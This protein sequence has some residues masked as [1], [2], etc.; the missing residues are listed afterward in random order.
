MNNLGLMVAFLLAALFNL[1]AAEW[2]WSVPAPTIPDRRAFLWVPPDCKQV[3]GLVVACHNMIEKSLFERSAFRAACAENDL[4]IVMIFSGHD[5]A[6][7]DDKNPDHPKRSALDIFLNPNFPKGEEDP[8]GAGEDL[9]KVLDA[10]AGE[11]G[12]EE[13]RHAPLMPVGHSSAGSFVWHLYK[14]D[15]SRIFAMMPFKTGSKED[16]PPGIPVFDVNSEWFEYGNSPMH[17]V[18]LTSPEGGARVAKFRA[19]HK[20]ALY[21]YYVDIGAGHCDASDDAI[22]IMRLFLKKVVAARIPEHAPKDASVPLKLVTVESGWLL[23]AATFGKPEGKPVAYADWK[24]DAKQSFWYLDKELAA[25]VQNHLVQQLAKKPQQI[26]FIQDGQ[27]SPDA[28]MY[29]FSPKFLDD[30]GTF[31]LQADFVDH[32]DHANFDNSRPDY[33]PPGTKL[34]HSDTPILFRVNSGAVMQVGSNT[35]RICPHAGPIVPQ[36]NPWEPTIV[37]YNLGDKDFRPADHPAHANVSIINKAGES[38][39][40][41]FIKISHQKIGTKSVKLAAKSSSGLP[42]QFFMVSGP[43]TIAGDTLKFDKIPARAKFPIRVL[44][45]AF[46]WGRSIEPKVQSVGPVTQ[47]FFIEN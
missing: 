43:A 28:R 1:P 17:N 22:G 9:Q 21:G 5:K 14:W 25:A 26:G 34:G 15:A 31:Q 45:S 47:E 36:G 27:P 16:G 40:L 7:D 19:N 46:Q 10:L 30:A 13:I 11:S 3:R 2:Q 20:D 32:I 41:E 38:Q 23:D 33:Y 42:V 24:G 18:S 39:T 8:K 35:F 12:Y 37:A 4:G 6:P 44:V 29:N